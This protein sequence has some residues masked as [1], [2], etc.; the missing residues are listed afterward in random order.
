M[1]GKLLE[2][3]KEIAPG[4]IAGG[5]LRDPANVTGPAQLGVIQAVAPSLR[6]E[7]SLINLRDA[8]RN[9]ARRRRVRALSERRSD[10]DGERVGCGASRL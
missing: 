4:V 7:A 1:S 9:R 2:L 6:V 8:R 5:V 10:L 3:L